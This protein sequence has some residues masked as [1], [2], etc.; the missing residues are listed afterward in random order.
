[1]SVGLEHNFMIYTPYEHEHIM[2]KTAG[3][4]MENIYLYEY[5]TVH[6][7]LYNT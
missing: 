3:N 2:H 1:V 7:T 4:F 6:A 5:I